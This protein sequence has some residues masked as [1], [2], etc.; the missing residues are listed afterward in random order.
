M[1]ASHWRIWSVWLRVSWIVGTCIVTSGRS[2][3]VGCVSEVTASRWDVNSLIGTRSRLRTGG[4]VGIGS[5]GTWM[6]RGR[7]GDNGGSRSNSR[8]GGHDRC[9]WSANSIGCG[10][11]DK[12]RTRRG[13]VLGVAAPSSDAPV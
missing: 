5:Q 13:G 2:G 11:G 12:R 9:S 10:R 6:G 8:E 3:R 4:R 7:V 1:G